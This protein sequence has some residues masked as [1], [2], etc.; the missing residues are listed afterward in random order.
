MPTIPTY[1]LYVLAADMFYGL[2]HVILG[3]KLDKVN[4]L[5]LMS[6]YVPVVLGAVLLARTLT[7]TDDPSFSF[8]Q[9]DLLML[10]FGVGII[11]FAADYCYIAAYNHNADPSVVS[12]LAL[13]TPVFTVFFS[14]AASKLFAGFVFTLPNMTQIAGYVLLAVG[15]LLLVEGSKVP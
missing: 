6:V 3:N 11:I 2:L 4:T 1:M 9:G 8:P 5:T 10:A 14:W 13:A 12:V 7:K 15:V